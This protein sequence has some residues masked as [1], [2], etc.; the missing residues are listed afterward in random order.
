M[1]KKEKKIFSMHNINIRRWLDEIAKRQIFGGP[2]TA[3]KPEDRPVSFP[4][5]TFLLSLKI[6]RSWIVAATAFHILLF[7]LSST[8]CKVLIP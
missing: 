6:L 7:Y 3:V 1:R 4:L 8:L 2:R 5:T